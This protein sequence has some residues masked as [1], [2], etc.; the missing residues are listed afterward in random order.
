[1][2]LKVV[3]VQPPRPPSPVREGSEEGTSPRPSFSDGVNWTYRDVR[4]LTLF[5]LFRTSISCSFLTDSDV[6]ECLSDG[7]N[8]GN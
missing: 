6:I 8:E 5:C 2:K 3:Y 7:G 1:M 4:S